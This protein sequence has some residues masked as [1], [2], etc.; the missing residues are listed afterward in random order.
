MRLLR[1]LYILALSLCLTVP[2]SLCPS[3]PLPHGHTTGH[4]Y[5]LQMQN[6]TKKKRPSKESRF[7]WATWIRTTQSWSRYIIKKAQATAEQ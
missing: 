6:T 7:S 3:V 2:L 1:Q 4:H 5:H